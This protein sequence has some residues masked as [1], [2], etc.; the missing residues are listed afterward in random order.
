MFSEK[1]CYDSLVEMEGVLAK[2]VKQATKKIGKKSTKVAANASLGS[3]G[4]VFQYGVDKG[5]VRSST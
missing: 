4:Q 5:W 1:E 3:A 2:S